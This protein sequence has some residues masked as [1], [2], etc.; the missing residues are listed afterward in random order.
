MLAAGLIFFGLGAGFAD[1]QVE[2]FERAAAKEIGQRLM[3][4]GKRVRVK[5]Q[6]DLAW[7]SL[8]R[9]S[10]AASNFSLD[11]LPLYTEP[12]RSQKG[13]LGMLSLELSNFRLRG[14]RIESLSAEIPDCRFDLSLALHE[15]RFRLSRSG[16][17]RG[18]VRVAERDLAEWIDTKY[19][20][21]KGCT[22]SVD[23]D[24]VWVEGYGEFLIVKTNFTVIASLKAVDG[25]KLVLDRARIYFDWRRADPMAAKMLL[26]TLNP[27]VDLD[28]D[29]GLA[30]AIHVDSI[31]LRGGAVSASGR[32][33]IPL[34][35][36]EDKAQ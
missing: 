6:P 16:I 33:K 30:D 35:P 7:G 29:L 2:R 4:E 32:T 10:I 1:G 27:V 17:G 25:T 15:R 24:V 19:A 21:I 14:L 36:A 31:T 28:K 3:G 8:H 23:R 18:T 12:R 11:G 20:E 26:D 22:V 34:A 9:A 5:A 13:R